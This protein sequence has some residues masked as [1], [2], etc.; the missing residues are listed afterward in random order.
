ML[1]GV[2]IFKSHEF[3][4][5]ALD[6]LRRT[7][8]LRDKPSPL[9]VYLDWRHD[10]IER[11]KLDFY[12]GHP[13]L[14]NIFD[15]YYGKIDRIALVISF[16]QSSLSVAGDVAEFGVYMGHTA[17]AMN[18]ALEQQKSEKQLYLF[19]SFSGMP[20][21]TYPLDG[22]WKKGDLASPVESV[23]EL[24]KGSQRVNILPGYFSET[25]PQHPN[26]RFSFCHVDCDL[27]SSVKECISYILPRLSIGGVIVFDDYG[28][29]DTQGAKAAIDEC[30]GQSHQPFV[31][32][33]TGQAV[34]L[35]QQQDESL[36]KACG[37]NDA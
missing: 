19:D 26:L 32:L 4:V 2:V 36:H 10:Q 23:R 13:V 3:R 28:F 9:R 20:E 18:R 27:Y 6:L 35:G 1:K 29:R 31:P 5:T 15:S 21:I 25:L 16:L 33:P 12:Q 24:F 30:F 37:V 14:G 17:A 8:A 11:L 22:V 7:P 34:Y